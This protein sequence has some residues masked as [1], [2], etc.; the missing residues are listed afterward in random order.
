MVWRFP[1]VWDRRSPPIVSE[2]VPQE[3]KPFGFSPAHGYLESAGRALAGVLLLAVLTVP[4]GRRAHSRTST[5]W[6]ATTDKVIS[7]INQHRE[8]VVFL[9]CGLARP[10]ERA[11]MIHSATIF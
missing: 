5:G 6:E 8:G 3:L 10:E 1:C 9:L 2:Y 4:A 11:L 7:L